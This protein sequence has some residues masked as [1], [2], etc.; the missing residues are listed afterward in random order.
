MEEV[1]HQYGMSSDLRQF[2][3]GRTASLFTAISQQP[4]AADLLTMTAGGHNDQLA[5][6]HHL[7]M[8]ISSRHRHLSTSTSTST[9]QIPTTTTMPPP[10]PPH[11][12]LLL[13]HHHHLF[14]S[15]STTTVPKNN[16]TRSPG[17]G[18]GCLD[19]ADQSGGFGFADGGNG[20]WP[21]Q[22]TLTL[23]EIRSRLDSK[24]KEANQ[25]APLWDE[26]SRYLI[27]LYINVLNH[28]YIHIYTYIYSNSSLITS[29]GFGSNGS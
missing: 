8:L 16:L 13:H 19:I 15:D 14:G 18:G 9:D 12:G 21:R 28:I 20:R 22:E 23:L 17:G 2:L 4:T 10:P 24:F 1:E 25:K 27:K 26:L 11:G 5:Q 7:E 6:E 3:N 29:V